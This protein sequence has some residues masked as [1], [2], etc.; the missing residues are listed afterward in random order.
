MVTLV[1]AGGL[2][3]GLVLGSAPGARTAAT[4]ALGALPAPLR[5]DVVVLAE[6]A[7]PAVPAVPAAPRPDPVPTRI[8]ALPPMTPPSLPRATTTPSPESAPPCAPTARACVDLSANRSWLLQNGRVT[9][10][11]VPITSGRP[12][13]RTPPGTFTVASK[14]RDH[15]SSIYDAEMPWSVFFNGGVAFHE[16]SLTV[17]SHGCI[18]LSPEAAETYF[19]ELSVGDVVQVV[20]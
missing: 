19:S 2:L 13:F 1:V 16:G 3:A 4:R 18:H 10:G 8:P 17:T 20:R 6:P 9:Y 15:V 11:P 12:G 7:Q 5:P 14:R